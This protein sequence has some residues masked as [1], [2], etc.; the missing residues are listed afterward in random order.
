MGALRDA[1]ESRQVVVTSHSPDLL[2][3]GQVTQDELLAVRSSEGTTRIARLDAAGRM[4][5]GE[6]LFGAG[7]LLRQDQL[8]PAAGEQLELSL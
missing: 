1:S 6:E 4:A 5:L 3:M 8:Q 7:E 2:D